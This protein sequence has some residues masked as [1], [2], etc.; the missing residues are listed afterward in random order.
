MRYEYDKDVDGLYI[1]FV[2]NIEEDK[3]NYKNEIWP[4]ELK[5]EIGLF[6]DKNGKLFGIE[7]M[8][9]SKYFNQKR[10]DE[11]SEENQ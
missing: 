8:P 7:V 5:N 11:F 10:L 6:F 4:E 2:N 3:E 9:A 1:W